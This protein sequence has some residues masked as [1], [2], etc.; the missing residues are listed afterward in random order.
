VANAKAS[1]PTLKRIIEWRPCIPVPG[2]KNKA[3]RQMYR[4]PT[5]D[6][7]KWACELANRYGTGTQVEVT[8]EDGNAIKHVYTF[9]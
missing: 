1:A 5:F 7:W 8:G 6:E 2:R 9:E 3:G 4:V